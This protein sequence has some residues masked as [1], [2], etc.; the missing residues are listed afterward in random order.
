MYEVRD[1]LLQE[2]PIYCSR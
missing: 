2:H 1:L